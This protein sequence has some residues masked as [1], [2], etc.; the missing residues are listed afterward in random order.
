MEINLSKKWNILILAVI[1]LLT[2]FLYSGTLNYGILTNDDTDFFT[3]YPEILNLSWN[4]ILLY[5]SSYHVTLYQPLT[6]LTF[7]INYSFSGTSPIALHAV[8]ILFHLL[9]VILVFIFF[10]TLLKKSVPA[11]LIAFLFAIHPINVEAITWISA[12]S[13]VMYA[14][15]YLLALIFYLKYISEQEKISTLFLVFFFFLLSLFCKVQAVTLPL[16]LLLIDYYSPRKKIKFL[17]LEKLPFFILSVLFIIIAF[18]NTETSTFLA[19]SKVKAFSNTDLL[20]LNGRTLFFYLQKFILPLNLSAVYVFPIKITS[21]LPVEYYIFTGLILLLGV[22]IFKYR[23]N[24]NVILGTGLFLLLLSINLPLISV[25]SIIYA[26]RYAYFPFLGLMFLVAYGIGWFFEKYRQKKQILIYG[27][28]L[29]I[30]IFGTFLSYET[31]KQN[32]KWE[33]DLTL[34]TD[35]IRNNPPVPMLAK[36]YR[37]RGNYLVKHQMIRESIQDYSTAIE[38]NPDDIDSYIFRAYSFLKLNEF[39]EAL[40]DLNK[41]IESRPGESVFY[42]NRAMAELNTGNNLSALSDCNK[43]LSIDSTNAEAYNFRAII[44]SQTGDLQGAEKELLSAIRFNNQYPEAYKNLGIILFRMNNPDQACHYWGI[45][46]QLGD[47]QAQ[48]LLKQNC[49]RKNS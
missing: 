31:W 6:V 22:V 12:R 48:Q 19:H 28:F 15:F 21:W 3:K 27:L 2:A 34:T 46:A 14:C 17:L 38:L 47:H 43:C 16:V 10:N 45:A 37:K 44:K 30:I 23:K 1:C 42:A 7:A 39:R 29:L 20:F 32:K 24:K 9:N 41:A 36:I 18:G 8:N 26:D 4:N 35:I 33:N 40:P 13:S 11:L 5:F 25:R 49:L